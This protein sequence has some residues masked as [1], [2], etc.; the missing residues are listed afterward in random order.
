[1]YSVH[2]V[3]HPW[4]E[5]LRKQGVKAAC[6]CREVR[7]PPEPGLKVGALISWQPIAL[8]DKDSEAVL[9]ERFCMAD[10]LP[11]EPSYGTRELVRAEHD[12]GKS[13]LGK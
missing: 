13:R 1:M 8:F 4:D 2:Y 6:L 5:K 7:M 3:E 11:I 9:F 10:S 12:L